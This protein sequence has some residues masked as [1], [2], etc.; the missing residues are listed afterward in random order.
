MVT[1]TMA[2]PVSDPDVILLR[3]LRLACVCGAL[4]EEQD[5]RQPYELDIDV[6]ADLPATTTDELADTID[7][8][9][10]LARVE[11]VTVNESF[12]LFERMAQRIAEAVL[13]DERIL[14][15]TVEV[16]KL[17]PPVTQFLDSSGVRIVRQR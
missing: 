5:R 16:R 14:R 12:Q 3:G 10:I 4:P 2:S 8:G 9:S 11:A 6:V 17:R 15:V 7:Y 13:A 1:A